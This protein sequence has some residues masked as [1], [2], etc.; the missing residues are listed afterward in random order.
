MPSLLIRDMQ[1]DDEYFVG[2]CTHTNESDILDEYAKQRVSWLRSRFNDGV[3]VKVA[4]LDGEQKGFLYVMPIEVCPTEPLG[5]NLMSIPCLFVSFQ[6]SGS[7]IGRALLAAAE[8]E[9]RL[10]GKQGIVTIGN[11]TD[12]WFMPGPFFEK[13]GF[14]VVDRQGER[15]I[16]WKVLD[17]EPAPPCFFRPNAQLPLVS[18][19][20]VLD[21]FWMTFC[22]A[23]DKEIVHEVIEEFND[24]VVL[25]E[26]CVDDRDVL[27]THQ[28]NRGLFVNGDKVEWNFENPKKGIRA[29]IV[30]AQDA[31]SRK[32][33]K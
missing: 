18:E 6:P 32:V 10:Q 17:G 19:K 9:V 30:E 14:S 11:Y 27:L 20:V 26:H 25:R 4:L 1:K 3:R 33:N 28:V 29:A 5:N 22:G 24:T 2:T 12:F 8:E 21:L 15:A 31:S 7:G 23:L 13:C 16:M